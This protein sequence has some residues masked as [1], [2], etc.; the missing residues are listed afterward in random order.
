RVHLALGDASAAGRVYATLRARLA[1]DLRVEPSAE[2]VALADQIRASA[3]ASRGSTPARRAVVES[4]PPSEL[5]APLVGRVAAF[6]QLVA[7]FQQV[8]RGQPQ[9]VLLV[10]R[11]VSAKRGWPAS[12]WPGPGPRE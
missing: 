12:L 9:A 4:G 7:S 5:T 10:G 3:A 2:T 1:E 6:S 11:R 8:R